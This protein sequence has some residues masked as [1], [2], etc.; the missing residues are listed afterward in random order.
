MNISNL[1][2]LTQH[3]INNKFVNSI[4]GQTFRLTNPAD[5]SF[6]A[7][8]QRGSEEDIDV[9]VKAANEAFYDGPWSRMDPTDRARCI[10]KLADLI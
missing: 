6:L 5:E 3:F 8:V 7:E 2:F 4:R 9:A 10:F 1:R